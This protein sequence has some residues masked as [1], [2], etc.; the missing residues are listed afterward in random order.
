MF[1]YSVLIVV[2]NIG[3]PLLAVH[4]VGAI[5]KPNQLFRFT[6]PKT[7]EWLGI[8]LG[9]KLSLLL[10]IIYAFL[11]VFI[12]ETFTEYGVG[13]FLLAWIYGSPIISI[14]AILPAAIYGILTGFLIGIL[15]R[16]FQDHFFRITL[17]MAGIILCAIVAAMSHYI[18]GIHAT[19]DFVNR[20]IGYGSAGTLYE[21]YPFYIGVPSIIYTLS[22]GWATWYIYK[23]AKH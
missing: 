2:A 18:L 20:A 21:T 23:E 15:V 12:V 10:S 7:P 9:F 22:G 16:R 19:F 3:L 17:I 1:L 14:W 5:R 4:L 11:G 8:G 6:L 13:G